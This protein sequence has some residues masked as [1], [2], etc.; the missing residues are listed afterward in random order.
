MNFTQFSL[1]AVGVLLLN[2]II[3]GVGAFVL[4]YM[5]HLGWSMI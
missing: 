2:L 5:A 4:G 1:T 3:M